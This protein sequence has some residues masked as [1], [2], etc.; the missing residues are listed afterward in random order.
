MAARLN[1]QIRQ[2][3][4]PMDS[5]R[6]VK[7]ADG[8]GS[9]VDELHGGRSRQLAA[10]RQQ[11]RCRVAFGPFGPRPNL[12]FDDLRTVTPIQIGVS[13]LPDLFAAFQL[14]VPL[15][16]A[17]GTYSPAN[18]TMTSRQMKEFTAARG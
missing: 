12:R 14:L 10:S 5:A 16:G 17:T 2:V 9:L 8:Q 13:Q 3:Q 6:S 4:T 18:Q 7:V 15:T 1:D 11:F